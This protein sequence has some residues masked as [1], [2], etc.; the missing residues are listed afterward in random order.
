MVINGEVFALD[1]GLARIPPIGWISSQRFGCNVDCHN[2]PDDCIRYE[3]HSRVRRSA[4][5]WSQFN[6][7]LEFCITTLHTRIL[8]YQ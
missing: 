2:Y 1:N 7:Q 3:L 4:A 5:E 8:R 6:F